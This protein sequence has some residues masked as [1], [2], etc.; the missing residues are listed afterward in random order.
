[1][2]ARNVVAAYRLYA[3]K[4]PPLSMQI[5]AYMAVVSKDADESPWFSQ[6]HEALAEFALGRQAPITRKDIAA[7]ERALPPLLKAGALTIGRKGAPRKEGP[8]TT[9]WRLNLKL[10]TASETPRKAW[11]EDPT[12]SVQETPRFPVEDPTVSVQT[13]HGNRGPEEQE[14]TVGA[15]GGLGGWTSQPPTGG[16]HTREADGYDDDTP[17]P[18][19]ADDTDAYLAWCR[20]RQRRKLRVI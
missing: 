7:V 20:D 13:P 3:G 17:P 5:L 2:G 15:N 18:E 4:V 12:E 9:L 19:L 16:A 8:R 10:S 1:M 14:E 11:D 6:G